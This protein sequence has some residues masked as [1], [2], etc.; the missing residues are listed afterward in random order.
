DLGGGRRKTTD[1]LNLEVGFSDVAHYG[2]KVSKG[3]VIAKVHAA[4]EAAANAAVAVLAR[5][6]HIDDPEPPARPVIAA[7]IVAA[8]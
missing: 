8:A 5:T 4:D 6:L 3:D 7:R 1:T 2:T